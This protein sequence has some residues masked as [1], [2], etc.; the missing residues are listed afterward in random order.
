[1]EIPFEEF[2]SELAKSQEMRNAAFELMRLWRMNWDIPGSSG[3]QS[4]I[5]AH[6]RMRDL[7]PDYRGSF[8][9]LARAIELSPRDS[10]N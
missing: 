8:I 10:E 2:V 1:M 7:L 3:Y 6:R 5:M 4:Y 9:S